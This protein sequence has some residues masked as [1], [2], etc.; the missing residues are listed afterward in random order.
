MPQTFNKLINIR[1][2]IKTKERILNELKILN[3]SI[4]SEKLNAED[5][6]FSSQFLVVSLPKSPAKPIST[7]ITLTQPS[8]L[9]Y[10][11]FFFP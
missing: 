3:N 8:K 11:L 2:E 4:G 1:V 6:S 7:Q 9:I 5:D 10:I